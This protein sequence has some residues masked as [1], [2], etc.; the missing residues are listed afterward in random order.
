MSVLNKLKKPEFSRGVMGYS[1]IEVDRYIAHVIARYN[2]VCREN[3]MLKEKLSIVEDINSLKAKLDA[4]QAKLE[5]AST[6]LVDT[7]VLRE[8][9]LTEAER[10]AA[11]TASLLAVINGAPTEDIL[12]LAEEG[13]LEEAEIVEEEEVDEAEEAVAEEAEEAAEAEAEEAPVAEAEPVAE[14]APAPVAPAPAPKTA[15]EKFNEDFYSPEELSDPDNL[16]DTE[17]FAEDEPEVVEEPEE[18]DGDIIEY[19]VLDS[20]EWLSDLETL[21]LTEEEESAPEAE[22][23]VEEAET[24]EVAEEAEAE[25]EIEEVAEESNEEA[26]AESAPEAEEAPVEAATTETALTPALVSSLPVSPITTELHVDTI[27]IQD[28]PVICT[29]TPTVEIFDAPELETVIEDSEPEF[30]VEFFDE[31]DLLTE[32]EEEIETEEAPE[33]EAEPEIEVEPEDELPEETEEFPAEEDILSPEDVDEADLLAEDLSALT[34]NASAD[35]LSEDFYTDEAFDSAF[36]VETGSFSDEAIKDALRKLVMG[37]EDDSDVSITVNKDQ[38]EISDFY[39]PGE[40]KDFEEDTL[41]KDL[42]RLMDIIDDQETKE[43]TPADTRTPAE[44]AAS[45]DF[46]SDSVHEDG[47]SFDAMTLATR[48]AAK[49]RPGYHNFFGKI[50]DGGMTDKD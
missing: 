10:Q 4:C 46:Y 32:A 11:F 12:A 45:L 22:E 49:K 26:E 30:E 47:E 2:D 29:A 33:D 35:K 23:S 14:P 41:L 17:I 16:V 28:E 40:D 13:S 48:H 44:I 6:P 3:A 9:I 50:E 1:P 36:D 15:A 19:G 31:A 21:D 7:D 20:A 38:P 24:E 25:E 27:E 37:D 42:R 18:E 39:I 5:E 34:E 43:E 8:L